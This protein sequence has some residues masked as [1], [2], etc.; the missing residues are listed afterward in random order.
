MEITLIT[1][2]TYPHHLGGVS[3][4]CDQLLREIPEHRFNVLAIGATGAEKKVYTPPG[5][6]ARVDTIPLWAHV[7]RRKAGPVLSKRFRPFQEDFFRSLVL[8]SHAGAFVGSLQMLSRYAMAGQLGAAMYTQEAVEMLLALTP[9][10]TRGRGG[11]VQGRLSVADAIEVLVLLEHFLRPLATPPPRADLCHSTANGLGTLPALMAKWSWGTPFLLTEH[12]VYLRER[13]LSYE[14]GS[15]SQPAR[16]VVL[17][18]FK[19]L[20]RVA[21]EHADI[22]APVC[23]YNRLWEV[24]NGTPP[25]RIRPV[26]NGIDPAAFPVARSEPPVPTLVWVGRVDPLKDVATLLRAF[27]KVRTEVPDCRLRLFGPIPE[28]GDDYFR[29]CVKLSAQLGLDD[30][31]ATFE[32]PVSPPAEA[33][34]AGHVFVFTSISEGFPYVVI[35]AMA[36]GLPVVATD[37]GGVAE[38]VGEAGILVPPR[39]SAAVAAACVRLL[40]RSDERRALGRAARS[41]VLQQFTTEHCFGTYRALYDELG[42]RSSPVIQLTEPEPA[43]AWPTFG[44]GT[45]SG[46]ELSAREPLGPGPSRPGVRSGYGVVSRRGARA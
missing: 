6:V 11:Q 34:Q 23:R 32:G 35:E 44:G 42:D 5:N 26:H 13:Y 20:T 41:R 37:V 18:F 31:A 43:L 17:R 30:G 29:K 39:N 3:V 24:A 1:E 21:Y 16:A 45:A 7:P 19:L 46:D 38:A 27:A 8:E 12:G 40:A 2:G 10:G 36:S 28:G 15:L 22:V 25:A 9:V 4:W 14:P 33:Y